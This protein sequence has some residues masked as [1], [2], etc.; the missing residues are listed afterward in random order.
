MFHEKVLFFY[1]LINF[2]ILK[3]DK[4]SCLLGKGK[5]HMKQNKLFMSI[6]E[7]R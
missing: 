2:N 4:L 3:N 7:K 5:S 6:I 1:V